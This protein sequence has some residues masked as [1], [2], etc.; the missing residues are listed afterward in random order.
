MEATVPLVRVGDDLRTTGTMQSL[1]LREAARFLKIR[2]DTLAKEANAGRIPGAKIGGCWVFLSEDLIA[3]V[4]SQY[5]KEKPC[6][7]KREATYG[8]FTSLPQKA[9]K[10]DA[11]LT[12]KTV[13]QPKSS[14]TT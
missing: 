8:T 9:K 11:V 3:Y 1:G 6:L 14:M 7:S 12:R 2:A 5:A 4:R 10:L 13:K